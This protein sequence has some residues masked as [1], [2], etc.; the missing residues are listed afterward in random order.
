MV[1]A[2]AHTRA[3]TSS[4]L[5]KER[6]KTDNPREG[7]E[8]GTPPPHVLS[9]RPSRHVAGASFPRCRLARR[10]GQRSATTLEAMPLASSQINRRRAGRLRIHQRLARRA[11]WAP[12]QRR[13]SGVSRELWDSLP[14]R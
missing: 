14:G 10:A 8:D 7:W 2:V 13:R 4:Y 5:K 6:K 9:R 3:S 12:K 1:L 11:C